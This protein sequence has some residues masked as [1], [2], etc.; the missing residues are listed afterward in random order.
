MKNRKKIILLILSFGIVFSNPAYG[1]RGDFVKLLKLVKNLFKSDDEKIISNSDQKELH[2]ILSLKEKDYDNIPKLQE[3]R[4][5]Y[6]VFI[7]NSEENIKDLKKKLDE[8]NISEFSKTNIESEI[9]IEE[10]KLRILEK[11]RESI[12]KDLIET[13]RRFNVMKSQTNDGVTNGLNKAKSELSDEERKR[14]F[15]PISASENIDDVNEYQASEILKAFQKE[16]GAVALV[17]RSGGGK[18]YGIEALSFFMKN[19]NDPLF[20]RHRDTNVYRIDIEEL[21]KGRDESDVSKILIDTLKNRPGF[22]NID[23]LQQFIEKYGE[24]HSSLKTILSE[25]DTKGK[26]SGNI[27]NEI[28]NE[29]FTDEQNIRRWTSIFVKEPDKNQLRLIAYNAADKFSKFYGIKEPNSKQF[30]MMLKLSFKHKKLGNPHVLVD[31]LNNLF[32]AASSDVTDGK[33]SIMVLKNQKL[34]IDGEIEHYNRAEKEDNNFEV[35]GP[36][37]REKLEKLKKISESFR[38]KIDE[39][40]EI[41]HK[42]EELRTERTSLIEKRQGFYKELEKLETGAENSQSKINEINAINERLENIALE[43]K[44]IDPLGLLANEIPKKHHIEIAARKTGIPEEHIDD[45]IKNVNEESMTEE[46]LK[47]I[48]S[49]DKNI[50]QSIIR[51]VIT[52]KRRLEK[53]TGK[54]PFFMVLSKNNIEAES[55]IKEISKVIYRSDTNFFEFP[56]NDLMDKHAVT[57]YWGSDKGLVGSHEA[58]PSDNALEVSNGFLSFM[59]SNLENVDPFIQ[60]QFLTA[61]KNKTKVKTYESGEHDLDDV[62]FFATSHNFEGFTEQSIEKLSTMD[63]QEKNDFLREL[64]IKGVDRS[65]VNKELIERM[66]FIALS[67]FTSDIDSIK[68]SFESLLENQ[69]NKMI[70]NSDFGEFSIRIQDDVINFLTEKI[71]NTTNVQDPNDIARKYIIEVI[72][73]GLNKKDIIGGDIIDF[74]ITKISKDKKIIEYSPRDWEPKELR[75]KARKEALKEFD[76]QP[77]DKYTETLE[78]AFD[79]LN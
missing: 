64:Y 52:Q 39:Y 63:K 26:L 73:E 1:G 65:S 46:V 21:F 8:E 72:S 45:V 44:K 51:R 25:K 6:D 27:T 12:N 10:K 14:I 41:F 31:M 69:I 24:V 22:Y 34:I 32:I 59:I 76:E 42:T 9:G 15:I 28:Y 18:T 48:P 5:E 66:E 71:L 49:V 35:L 75:D 7:I 70:Q 57:K 30:E 3:I 16:T 43:M 67:E 47:R 61:L 2:P 74:K 23:E 77:P 29:H 56:G 13:T 17:G 20:L 78:E 33:D 38:E 4:K 11:E 37:I 36:H 53:T 55:L 54:I 40:W 19:S 60:G 58:S 62:T 68:A 50:V 79:T